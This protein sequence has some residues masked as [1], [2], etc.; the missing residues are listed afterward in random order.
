MRPGLAKTLPFVLWF[1]VVGNAATFALIWL[2]RS[3]AEMDIPESRSHH[4]PFAG[5]GLSECVVFGPLKNRNAA[6]A[7]A[8]EIQ[9]DG[10]RA[11]VRGRDI[12][13]SPDFVVH[14][15][16]SASR[17]LALRRLRELKD[18][19][20]DGHVISDGELANAVSVGVFGL[21]AP[22]EARRL[23]IASL[24]YD[25]H[26]ARIERRRTV[27]SVYADEPPVGKPNGVPLVPCGKG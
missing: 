8:D 13:G 18:H 26:V 24:G 21:L 15:E 1:L 16:P 3:L 20:V 22:A 10:G 11:M 17:D 4:V 9:R 2:E 23:R 25:V 14:V 7:L 6:D 5:D 19:S 12:L 27:Y